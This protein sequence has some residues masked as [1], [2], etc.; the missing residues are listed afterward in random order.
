MKKKFLKELNKAKKIL[1]NHA[2]EEVNDLVKDVKSLIKE[3]EGVKN[4]V[5]NVKFLKNHVN[6]E[7]KTLTKDVKSLINKHEEDLSDL[8]HKAK[9]STDLVIQ[10]VTNSIE[11]Y[12]NE[13]KKSTNLYTQS[14]DI[15][16]QHRD[17]TT[18]AGNWYEIGGAIFCDE[19]EL[20]PLN[21]YDTDLE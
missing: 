6:E 4:L 20:C 11:K 21:P 17:S 12:I 5:K 1:K 8:V 10:E 13:N 2:N 7:V 19:Q 9:K 16:G 15:E 18:K 14:D 3:N